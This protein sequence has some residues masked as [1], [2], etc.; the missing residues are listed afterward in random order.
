MRAVLD[1]WYREHSVSSIFSLSGDVDWIWKFTQ[2]LTVVVT[3]TI[4]R[5]CHIAAIARRVQRLV[6]SVVAAKQ[7]IPAANYQTDALRW[8]QA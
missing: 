5:L 7:R 1:S 3:I 6:V 4:M 8:S 2:S